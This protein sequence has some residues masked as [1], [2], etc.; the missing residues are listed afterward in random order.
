MISIDEYVG[1]WKDSPDWD[2][3]RQLNATALLAKCADLEAEMVAD[4]V[5][6]PVNPKTGTQVSG[7]VYGGFRPQSCPIGAPR[8]NHKE[9]RAVD[10][11]DP[12]KAIANW[13]MGHQPR[14]REIGIWIENPA[15]TIG[16]CHWQSVQYGSYVDGKPMWFNP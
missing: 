12:H 8:S 9:G 15:A 11:F 4:G 2:S 7:E 1:P 14:L 3:E 13:C 10:R 6:F 5:E 16:W